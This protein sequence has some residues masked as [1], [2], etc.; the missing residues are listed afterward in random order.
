MPIGHTV[1]KL[2]RFK[3]DS[4]AGQGASTEQLRMN[5]SAREPGAGQG[6]HEPRAE[7]TRR[8][9]GCQVAQRV[10]CG[11]MGEVADG[12]GTHAHAP[13]RRV[14]SG[15]LHVRASHAID[16]CS[17]IWKASWEARICKQWSP[18]GCDATYWHPL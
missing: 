18:Q 4:L 9:R 15:A 13:Q 1:E 2:W 7:A 6:R 8:A 17:L 10:R 12:N 16:Q 3:G 14:R 5:A 11:V